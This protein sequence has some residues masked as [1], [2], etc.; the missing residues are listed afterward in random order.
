MQTLKVIAILIIIC[1]FFIGNAKSQSRQ[2]NESYTYTVFVDNFIGTS[3]DRTKWRV[4]NAYKRGIGLLKDIP[5][6]LRVQN[7]NLELTM[8][9]CPNCTAGSYQGNYAGAEV[10]SLVPFP[11]GIFECRA[12][13]AQG[14]GS[15]PAFWMIG[16]DGT[17]CPPGSYANE[18]D[19]AENFC[20]G[21]GDYLEHNIHHY[22]PTSDCAHSEFHTVDH[23]KYSFNA[24]N[25]YH[26]FKCIRTP[27]KISY[28]VDGNLKHEIL[29]TGQICSVT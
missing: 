14:D 18:I 23:I 12:K 1:F 27:T 10:A 13:Y 24:N 17:P 3:L 2:Y 25:S 7:D 19:I 16:G 15:W 8:V 22:H 26:V 20:G 28:Y 11:Y 6:T 21:I 29:N 9:S 5:A 4:E